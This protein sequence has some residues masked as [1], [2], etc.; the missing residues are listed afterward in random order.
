MQKE[1]IDSVKWFDF[2]DCKKAVVN[3]TI[4]NCIDIKE[5]QLIEEHF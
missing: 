4:P 2:E 5:L 1:E 3:N